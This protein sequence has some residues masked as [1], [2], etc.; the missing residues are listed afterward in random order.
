FELLDVA[1]ANA[2][3]ERGVD[4]LG[5]LRHQ[6]FKRASVCRPLSDAAVDALSERLVH[7]VNARA[8]LVE[9]LPAEIGERLLELLGETV[10]P[11]IESLKAAAGLG[12]DDRTDRLDNL[13]HIPGAAG[14]RGAARKF[15]D[16]LRQFV[17]A[18]FQPL[19]R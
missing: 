9:T 11:L 14:Q 3:L 10:E 13:A 7:I 17:E 2:R 19:Q 5:Q 12:R 18:R 4:F 15:F 16:A 1:A 6:V 8:K